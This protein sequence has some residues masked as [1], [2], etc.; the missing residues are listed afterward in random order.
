MIINFFL[1]IFSQ[2]E[3]FRVKLKRDTLILWPK[4]VEKIK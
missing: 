2:L 4:I 3:F 1:D